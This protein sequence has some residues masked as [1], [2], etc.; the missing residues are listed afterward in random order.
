MDPNYTPEAEA[1]R[2]KIQGVLAENL[3]EDWSGMGALSPEDRE[4]FVKDWRNV[5]AENDL[6]AVA[7]P[8]EFGGAGLSLLERTV[9]TEELAK[10]GLPA[11]NDNDVFSIS[12]LGHT[13]IEWGTEEQQRHFLPRILDGTDVWCQGYSEPNSGSDLAS[14]ATKAELD[15][16]EWI[17]NGQKIWTS[18]G[19]RANWI[20]VL[21]RTDPTVR[22]Q[23][24]ISFLLCPIDQPGVEVRPIVN[25]SRHH[26]FNEVFFTDARTAKGNAVGGINNGWAVANTL[27]AYE[28]GDDAT[29]TGIR[30]GDELDRLIA[31]A[32]DNGRIDDPTIRQRLAWC[33]SK[34]QIMRYQGMRLVTG[35]LNGYAQ[36]PESS[37]NKLLWS[38]YHHKLTELALDIIGA[39]ALA[40]SGRDAA[41]GA[42]LDDIGSPYSSQAWV[43]NFIGAR[44]GTIYSGSS[45]IQRN[46]IGERVLAL[47]REPRNDTGPWNETI[48]S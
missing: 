1:F 6:L 29:V 12:M 45:E 24:G 19:H 39:E 36:G 40:P 34:V 17:I 10:A 14:L 22:K 25:A 30:H 13:L 7:W 48:R 35:A 32:K 26:D 31:V 43:T 41:S 16:D 38:E 28:R 23:A 44:P 8:V 15:G 2:R 11:G 20:F 9:V 37:L 21:C 18:G 5:L 33:Y 27:L 47:P 4:S 46:I 42:G 3:P